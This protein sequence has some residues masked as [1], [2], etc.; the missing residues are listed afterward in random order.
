MTNNYFTSS[1][2]ELAQR[3]GI[4]LWD[5]DVL[6]NL[7]CFNDSYNNNIYVHDYNNSSE[8]HAFTDKEICNDFCEDNNDRNY[9]LDEN[10]SMVDSYV[11]NEPQVSNPYIHEKKHST[12][13]KINMYDKENGIYPAGNYLVGDDIESGKYLLTSRGNLTAGVSIYESY[14]KY[15][16]DEPLSHNSFRGEYHLSLRENGLFVDV[17]NADMK[18]L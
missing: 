17:D 8:N 15:K 7:G 12:N 4:I 3:N 16:K 6:T 2:K 11:D 10:K 13:E 14:S 18:R 5:R 9:N 1:A